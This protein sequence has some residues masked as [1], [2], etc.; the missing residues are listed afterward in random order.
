MIAFASYVE[1]SSEDFSQS[2]SAWL[3]VS[4]LGHNLQ[5]FLPITSI[6]ENRN[7]EVGKDFKTFA[8]CLTQLRPV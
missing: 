4:L 3:K 6:G 5:L 8:Y 2:F 1:D 7:R